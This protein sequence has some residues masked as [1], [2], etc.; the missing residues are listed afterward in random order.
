MLA[1][2]SRGDVSQRSSKR[3]TRNRILVASLLLFNEQGEPNTTTNQIADEIDISPGNLHYHFKTKS[4]LVAALLDAFHVDMREILVAP[5]DEPIAVE[6]FWL[7]LHLLLERIAAY[8]F[9]FR[10][11]ETL[12]GH[13]PALAKGLQG[14]IKSLTVTV[15]GWLEQLEQHG[16]LNTTAAD[17]DELCKSLVVVIIFSGRYDSMTG[18]TGD[19][20]MRAARSALH[21]LLP[22]L[23]RQDMQL[24]LNLADRYAESD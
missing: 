15:D 21:Q 14:F 11:V 3:D 1:D 22:Y 16:V 23:D 20:L 2:M 12:S 4:D 18:E 19:T 24:V 13:Y 8:R 17:R 5:A 7:F 10:D 9:L 6:D